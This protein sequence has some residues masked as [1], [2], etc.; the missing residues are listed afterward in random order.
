MS[1][2]KFIANKIVDLEEAKR[3]VNSWKM[4]GYKVV[5]TNGCFD[6]LHKGHVTYLSQATDFGNKLVV[7]L[8]SDDSVRRRGKGEGRPINEFSARAAVI[9]S[10]SSVDL[11]V[12]FDEDT[13]EDLIE[14]LI[15]SVVAKGADYN[16]MQTDSTKKDYIVG[17]ATMDRTNGEVV[18]IPLVEGFSTTSILEKSRR[19]N[20]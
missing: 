4:R 9:A 20:E 15:P 5:F 7:G 18:A 16:P 11:V 13:P 8:N 19:S 10:L 3:R 12:E 1:R 17:K 14:A 6:I 2:L